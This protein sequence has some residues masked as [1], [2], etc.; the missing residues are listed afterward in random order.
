LWW[1][2]TNV[3]KAK[4]EGASSLFFEQVK[5]P[6]HTPQG[7]VCSSFNGIFHNKQQTIND[8]HHDE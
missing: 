5:Q 2:V 7:T 4:D 8:L 1:L 3:I 6:T